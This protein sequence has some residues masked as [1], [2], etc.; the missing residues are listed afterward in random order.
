MHILP[1][2]HG[3]SGTYRR[4]FAHKVLL[5]SCWVEPRGIANN[6]DW[7]LPESASIDYEAL[8]CQPLLDFADTGSDS[9]LP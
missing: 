5:G 3:R 8:L 2:G 7:T 1:G 4:A 9:L 6:D